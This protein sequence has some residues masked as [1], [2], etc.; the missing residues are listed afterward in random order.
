MDETPV[1]VEAQ[2][3]CRDAVDSR[4]LIQHVRVGVCLR[5]MLCAHG[6]ERVPVRQKGESAAPRDPERQGNTLAWQLPGVTDPWL[7]DALSPAKGPVT[8]G[9]RR[10]RLLLQVPVTKKKQKILVSVLSVSYMYV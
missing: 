7:A 6:S 10:S 3:S 9:D 1:M 2:R 8:A 4:C 5:V